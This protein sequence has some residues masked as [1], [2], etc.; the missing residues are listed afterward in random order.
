MVKEPST[1]RPMPERPFRIDAGRLRRM[2]MRTKL[3]IS[4]ILVLILLAS[5]LYSGISRL[6]PS[7]LSGRALKTAQPWVSRIPALSDRT[8]EIATSVVMGLDLSQYLTPQEEEIGSVK[9]AIQQTI[10]N[11]VKAAGQDRRLTWEFDEPVAMEQPTYEVGC[12]TTL[13]MQIQIQYVLDG[14]QRVFGASGRLDIQII[15]L[16]DADQKKVIS[17]RVGQET[18]INLDLT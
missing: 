6:G 8:E 14:S 13:P 12:S 4:S 3:A 2:P 11:Q 9:T 10:I 5:A 18:S 16:V 17:W 1:T 15:L 7:D